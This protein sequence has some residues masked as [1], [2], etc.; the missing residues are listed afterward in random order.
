M[1]IYLEH[2]Q[3]FAAAES[4]PS[5]E[6]GGPSKPICHN[7]CAIFFSD[8]VVCCL[9]QLTCAHAAIKLLFS[10]EP[11]HWDTMAL[12]TRLAQQVIV[13]S[14]L[15]ALQQHGHSRT[16]PL[17]SPSLYQSALANR[18]SISGKVSAG[19]KNCMIPTPKAR[20]VCT[21]CA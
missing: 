1:S 12:R 3:Q 21:H 11:N 14:P 6:L 19:I 18:V 15:F 17:Q 5:L 7:E 4:W 16:L 20:E 10:F 8:L 2:F 13:V 9:R